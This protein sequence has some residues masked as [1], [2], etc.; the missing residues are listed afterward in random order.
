MGTARRIVNEGEDL[1]ASI[2]K[3][4]ELRLTI[5]AGP[6]IVNKVGMSPHEHDVFFHRLRSGRKDP[7]PQVAGRRVFSFWFLVGGRDARG[8]RC[9]K[10]RGTNLV[11]RKFEIAAVTFAPSQ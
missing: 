4:N 11:S 3:T 6:I 9:E 5:G 1:A 10:P 8:E 7:R 2:F